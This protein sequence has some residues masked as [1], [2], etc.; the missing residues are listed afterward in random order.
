LL[1]R[2]KLFQ[3]ARVR[4]SLIRKAGGLYIPTDNSCDILIETTYAGLGPYELNCKGLTI[5][6][7]SD[8]PKPVTPLGTIKTN[9]A[10][11]YVLA[12]VYAQKNKLDDAL[13]VNSS[14][15][16]VESTSSNLF[17]IDGKTVYTPSLKDGC[18]AGTMRKKMIELIRQSGFNVEEEA[19]IFP[20]DLL[21]MEEVFLTN[22]MAGIKWVAAYQ[23]RR[24]YKKKSQQFINK[25]NQLA[26]F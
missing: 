17:A 5:G 1:T 3:A 8:I 26:G 11:I 12:G 22:A 15:H 14:G 24:Y 23:N 10:L 2:N 16:L 7:Y 19:Q 9:N 4:V 21:K 25:L 6:I 13:L 20:D 18:V